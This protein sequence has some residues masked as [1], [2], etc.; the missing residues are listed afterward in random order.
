[1]LGS[2]RAKADKNLKTKDHSIEDRKSIS[3]LNTTAGRFTSVGS[4][5]YKNGM[6]ERSLTSTSK[7][8]ASAYSHKRSKIASKPEIKITD[9]Y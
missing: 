4:N 8:T 6:Q 5:P 7:H 2:N 3:A 9:I 1:M